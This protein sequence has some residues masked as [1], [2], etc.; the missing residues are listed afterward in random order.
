MKT[1]QRLWRVQNKRTLFIG[2][3]TMIGNNAILRSNADIEEN[4]TIGAYMEVKMVL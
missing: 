2:K 3:N 4:C 1:G